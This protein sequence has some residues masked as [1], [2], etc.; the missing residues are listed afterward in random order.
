M[1]VDLPTRTRPRAVTLRLRLPHGLRLTRV[2]VDGKP[3]RRF[4][5]GS[6]TVDLSGLRGTVELM[7]A[8]AAA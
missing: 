3:W 7:A 1:S 6:G 4:D 8:Y 2:T 5:R